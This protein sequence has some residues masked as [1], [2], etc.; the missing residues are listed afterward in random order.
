MKL[1]EEEKNEIRSWNDSLLVFKTYCEGGFNYVSIVG[2][3][4]VAIDIIPFDMEN[5][6]FEPHMELDDLLNKKYKFF[7]ATKFVEGKPSSAVTKTITKIG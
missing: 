7:S 6:W 2:E 5:D 1:I 4:K 3:F